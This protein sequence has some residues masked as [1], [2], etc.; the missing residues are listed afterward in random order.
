MT[1]DARLEALELGV[2][3]LSKIIVSNIT[4]LDAILSLLSDVS[5]SQ[6]S[7]F[8]A[9][10]DSLATLDV[11]FAE[12][13]YFLE[14]RLQ[15][16]DQKHDHIVELIS[17]F[18]ASIAEPTTTTALFCLECHDSLFGAAEKST[19]YPDV[20]STPQSTVAPPQTLDCA[21]SE[22]LDCPAG[23]SCVSTIDHIVPDLGA[24]VTVIP[25]LSRQLSVAIEIMKH[26]MKKNL[27][28]S[29]SLQPTLKPTLQPALKPCP[30]LDHPI[31]LPDPSISASSH[32]LP[33]QA[34]ERALSFV[35]PAPSE[36][37]DCISISDVE[38]ADDAPAVHIVTKSEVDAMRL[39]IEQLSL[40]CD[41]A[42]FVATCEDC[43]KLIQSLR[44][45]GHVECAE[46]LTQTVG[47][48]LSELDAAP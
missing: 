40:T 28:L 47:Q 30:E 41:D 6:T 12:V 35:L 27:A 7:A 16:I 25:D 1:L 46:M 44:A 29:K 8:A 20:Y 24:T 4:S 42:V 18:P 32:S 17:E 34:S 48:R 19:S 14:S 9:S 21:I 15:I 45:Q 38:S 13:G 2:A 10:H 43:T 39:Q 37:S 3:G 33:A 26:K 23:A 31:A 36:P 5:S 11:R 22:L